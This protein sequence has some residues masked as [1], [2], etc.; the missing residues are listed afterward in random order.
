MTLA[1][2]I[3]NLPA[4]VVALPLLLAPV[5]ALIPVAGAAWLLAVIGNGG[6]L[7][8]ALL[9][10]GAVTGGETFSYYLGSWPPPWGIEFVVDA[11]SAFTVLVM[12]SL[13]FVVTLFARSALLAEIAEADA[14]KAYAAWLLACGGLSGL[15]MTGDAFNLFVFLEISALSSVILIALGAG[16][17]RRALIAGYNY[18]IIGAVGATFYVVGVGFIYAVTGSLNMVDLAERIPA[19]PQTTVVAVGFGFMM[20]GILVKAAIFPVHIWLPAA[21]AFAPSAVS[22]LLAAIATKASLYVLARVV[23]DV[24]AGVPDLTALALHYALIPLALGGIFIG[25]V[26]A[27]YENDIKKLLAFSSVAQIGYIA[28]GFAVAT[29]AGVAAGFVHIGNHAL[30]KGGLFVAVGIYAVALGRRINLDQMVGLGRRM[31]IT[32]TAFLICGLSLIGMPLTAGFISKIYLVRA[33]LQ[34][35]MIMVLVLVMASSALSVAYLW[36]IVEVLWQKG[37]ETAAVRETPALY[38]PLWILA[39]ANI[40]FGV[41]PAPLVDAA[42]RAAMQLTGGA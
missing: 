39:L 6:A 16:R 28:L 25:T 4:L 3:A 8:S 32:T 36:K 41:A 7:L 5:A 34:A 35:D 11:A 14:G 40:W 12:A 31:P 18:L 23:F 29:T 30:I 42:M 27:I 15:V 20:A 2:I 17:D 1:Q 33:L 24:F 26:L 13:A 21:Y 9:L 10:Q 37:A 38:L 19:V 22:S